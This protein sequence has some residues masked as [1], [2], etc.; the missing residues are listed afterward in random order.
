MLDP[1][2]GMNIELPPDPQLKADLCAPTYEIR[3]GNVIFVEKKEAVKKR[4]GRSPDRADAV[5]YASYD[6]SLEFVV[7]ANDGGFH[8]YKVKK[9]YG[10]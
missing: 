6:S 5:L 10:R 4:I 2:S 8:K 7:E 9:A 3:E 1:A